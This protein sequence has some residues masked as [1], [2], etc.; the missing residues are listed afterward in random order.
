MDVFGNGTFVFDLEVVFGLGEVVGSVF[1]LFFNCLFQN[2][3]VLDVLVLD[4]MKYLC[5]DGTVEVG[6][7]F[8]E[9]WEI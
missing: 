7:G 8:C 5:G 4:F 6:G 3:G 1:L 9:F 2:S